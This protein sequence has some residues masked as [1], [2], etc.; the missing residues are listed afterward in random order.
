[1]YTITDHYLYINISLEFK[2]RKFHKH[3]VIKNISEQKTIGN[4]LICLTEKN[5]KNSMVI[6]HDHVDLFHHFDI[7]RYQF[8]KRHIYTEHLLFDGKWGNEYKNELFKFISRLFSI[9]VFEIL[10]PKTLFNE[11]KKTIK[12]DIKISC[13]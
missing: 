1:M 9:N 4:F 11:K 7:N 5:T 12:N 6:Y 8:S 2:K 13:K 3:L 10:K